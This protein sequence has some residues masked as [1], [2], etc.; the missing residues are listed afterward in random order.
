MKMQVDA[1]KCE[2]FGACADLCP[3]L[4]I[5]DEWGYASVI[6]DGT[7][8]DGDEQAAENALAACPEMA[9]TKVH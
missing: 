6:G 1:T 3:S 2:A 7:V 4:F 9:I 5:L 8:P